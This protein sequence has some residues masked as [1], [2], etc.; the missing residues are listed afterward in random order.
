MIS[1]AKV[2]SIRKMV[3][4]IGV[5]E[6][7]RVMN[8]KV[9][10][11]ERYL[12]LEKKITNNRHAKVLCIDIETAPITTF[13]WQ[14]KHNNYIHT[15][16]VTTEWF[17]ICWRGKWLFDDEIHG[18]VLTPEEAI[19]QSDKRIC[20]SLWKIFD[21]ADVL[22][23]HNI[24]NFDLKKAQTQFY[25]KHKFDRFSPVQTIDTLKASRQLF[26]PESHKLDWLCKKIGLPGKYDM[27]FQVWRDCFGESK[28]F[29]VV[30]D[31]E[32]FRS[33]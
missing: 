10:S 15:Q 3:D 16:Q 12:L 24:N 8:V 22:I 29:D 6:T 21:D 1:P 14:L 30:S 4:E 2:R 7:A 11:I 23:G 32:T 19:L 28:R 27:S 26:S 13:V 31:N 18:D 9:G 20:R 5:Q 25:L 33:R 17:I